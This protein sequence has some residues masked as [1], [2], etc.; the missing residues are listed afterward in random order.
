MGSFDVGGVGPPSSG[1]EGDRIEETV[2]DGDK[3]LA[4]AVGDFRKITG[5]QLV[6]NQALKT[7]ELAHGQS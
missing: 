1:F 4:N 5:P 2:V 3:S 6:R 7:P